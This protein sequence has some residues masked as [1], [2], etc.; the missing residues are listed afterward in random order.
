VYYLPRLPLHL[1]YFLI[2]YFL[3]SFIDCIRIAPAGYYLFTDLFTTLL[4]ALKSSLR[5][6][7]CVIIYYLFRRQDIF[8]A[9]VYS[10]WALFILLL[11]ILLC[12][13]KSWPVFDII[14]WLS[15]SITPLVLCNQAPGILLW[16]ID[17]L[18]FSNL[19]VL[20]TFQLWA[21]VSWWGD[22]PLTCH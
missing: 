10:S 15:L 7:L 6:L 1:H 21:L 18:L 17:E 14:M 8:I 19:A 22:V 13:L 2:I 3:G 11:C 5:H 9:C 12:Y 16:Y 4:I 20:L